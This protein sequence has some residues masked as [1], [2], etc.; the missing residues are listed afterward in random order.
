M[1]R[2]AAG[3]LA[4]VG[5]AAVLSGAPALA[6]QTVSSAHTVVTTSKPVTK[7]GTSP[8]P[9][10]PVFTGA[11]G[12]SRVGDNPTLI[13]IGAASLAGAVAA[14]GFGRRRRSLLR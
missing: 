9:T 3:V 14:L 13:A 6:S 12:A 8:I 2:V 7:A 11:G 4:T 5:V 1:V 10:G